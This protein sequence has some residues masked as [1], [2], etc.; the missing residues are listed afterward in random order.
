MLA[1]QLT[2]GL[3]SRIGGR[4]RNEDACGYWGTQP[5]CCVLADGAGGHGGGDIAARTAVRSVLD[6]FA[7]DPRCTPAHALGLMHRAN[8]AVLGRQRTDPEHGD[9]RATL[10]VLALDPESDAAVWAHIG[11]SRL[12]LFRD[13]HLFAQTRDHSL[14]QSLVEAGFADPDARRGNP[15]RNV[16]TGSLGIDQGFKPDVTDVTV[17]AQTGDAFLLCSDGFWEFVD[18]TA[19]EGMLQ[20]AS[21]AQSWLD[22]M[23][24]RVAHTGGDRQDNY[25]A[26]AVWYGPMDFSTRIGAVA[27][28]GR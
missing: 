26:I 12:Y 25:S 11:D 23:A 20:R 21:S 9:M 24:D 22:A 3:V 27:V 13:G 15:Q 4:D 7:A 6:G 5:L 19:M 2:L 8:A 28:A 1:D 14:Y 10:V 17:K 16:L 18:E